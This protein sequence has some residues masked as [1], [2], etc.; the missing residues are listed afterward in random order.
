MFGDGLESTTSVNLIGVES[1]E[2]EGIQAYLLPRDVGMNGRTCPPT[3]DTVMPYVPLHHEVVKLRE[4]C[5]S[6]LRLEL[7]D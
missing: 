4:E 7:R 3:A 2:A 6:A 1:L 5:S